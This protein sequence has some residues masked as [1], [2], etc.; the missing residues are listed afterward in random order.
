M[1]RKNCLE[2]GKFIWTYKSRIEKGQSKYCSRE[3]TYKNQPGAPKGDMIE[4][5]CV[6]CG[7]LFEVH[8][9][10][11]DSKFC[12]PEC[13]YESKRDIRACLNC[14]NGFKIKKSRPDKYCSQDC[15]HEHNTKVNRTECECIECGCKFTVP[16]NRIKRGRGKYCSEACR[17][18]AYR[19]GD[20][21]TCKNCEDV[22]Y[23]SQS[24][25]DRGMTVY[26][27]EECY[28]DDKL[29]YPTT[30]RKRVLI[31]A[32]RSNIK[33]LISKKAGISRGEVPKPLIESWYT[34]RKIKRK[35][36]QYKNEKH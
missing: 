5:V 1:I 22:F 7:S 16:K 26:C 11:R 3:C 32:S 19:N 24:R 6:E 30:G 23:R 8:P 33:G 28:F 14:G 21:F 29:I 10:R 9:Y 4:K 13:H 2:C 27:S 12:S 18:T 17:D 31:R 20:K 35:T 34:L 36:N 25:I 15:S